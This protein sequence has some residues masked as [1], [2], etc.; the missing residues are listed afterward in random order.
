MDSRSSAVPTWCGKW[1]CES[2]TVN[3]TCSKVWWA[4]SF[5]HLLST[6]P[7]FIAVPSSTTSPCGSG[8]LKA[9]KLKNNVQHALQLQSASCFALHAVAL[10]WKENQRLWNYTIIE[11]CLQT[12]RKC[13]LRWQGT[14]VGRT[15][16]RA[17]S[18]A[19]IPSSPWLCKVLT[20]DV[21]EG[22]RP[23]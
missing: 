2:V 9:W 4:H 8:R 1:S 5:V 22:A 7:C 14:V 23:S 21:E 6:R 10:E 20:L 18:A 13:D 15:G 17:V 3:L 12:W 11:A 16:P 19:P